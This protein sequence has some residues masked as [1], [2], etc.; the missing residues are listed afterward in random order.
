VQTT[1]P[2]GGETRRRE[3]L[4]VPSEERLATSR[5]AQYLDRVNR[6][7]QSRLLTYDELWRWSVDDLE[8]FWRSLWDHFEIVAS[9]PPTAVL[10][11]RQMPGTRWFPGARLNWAENLLR[12]ATA[13]RPAIVCVREQ[14]PPVETSWAE[15][16]AQVA[17]LAAEL[18]A[19]GVRP[20]DRV[21][22]YL[23]NIPQAVVA[24]LATA[25]VGAIWSCCAPDFGTKGVIDRFQQ[26]E[27]AVLIAVDGYRFGGKEID[28]L[29]VVGELRERLPSVRHTLIVRNLA[30]DRPVP[31]GS[32]AFDAMTGGDA[33]PRYEQVPF[34]HPLWILY[35]SGTTGLPKGIVQSHGGILL[36]HLKM[37]ALHFDLGPD[38]RFFIYASTAWMVW[39]VLVTGLAVGA[40]IITYDGSPAYPE[41]DALFAICAEQQVTR[42]G[43]GAAYLTLCEKAESRPGSRYDLSALRAI[44]STGSPLPESTWRWVYDAVKRDLLLGSDCGGTDVCSAF[45][46][47]NPMLP[48]YAGEMQAPYL[49]VRIEAWSEDGRPVIGEVGE[50]VI[51][52][53]MPSMPVA[54]WD[55]PDGTRLRK[56]YFDA[57]PGVWRHGDWMTVTENG[58]YIVHG[59]SDSTINRGGVRMGSADIYAAV[60]GLPEIADSLVI[61]AELPD[62]DYYMPLFVVLAPGARLDDDLI[63]RIQR[64]IRREVSPRHVPDDIVEAPA[65]PMTI[66]GKRLEIPIKS[67]LQGVPEETALNRATVAN[68][69]VLDWYV[70]FA[71][72]Y[73]AGR[74][75]AGTTRGGA[76]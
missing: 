5:M 29:D 4:W 54:L 66:T 48:V 74:D 33:A 61:G 51:T 47:T 25:S 45:I 42:F 63:R 2:A 68:P 17:S 22:A 46:G 37:H 9:Q 30:P 44:T 53:P 60:N 40:T 62:G 28:R 43:V 24:L 73:R 56:A 58:T 55:D 18:R 57:F 36:E 65:V 23:P 64:A 27:P 70:N 26:I 11:E 72:R 38:D 49:G 75:T 34:D 12:H 50:M 52:A 15:L 16:T 31:A 32:L 19:L 10:A 6:G 67:L 20:G 7:R 14:G 59:R 21:A 8:G 41:P 71:A 3:L 35:S 69:D 39:N 1:T 76:R 13:E